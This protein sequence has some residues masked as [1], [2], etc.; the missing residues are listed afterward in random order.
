MS[1]VIIQCNTF[2]KPNDFDSLSEKIKS[3]FKE[4][5]LVLPAY[6]ELRA[7]IDD[8]ASDIEIVGNGG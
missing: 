6:C 1:K 7:V 5:I 2:L 3:D 4:D 8:N